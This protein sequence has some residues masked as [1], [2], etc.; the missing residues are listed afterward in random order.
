MQ[1]NQNK[2]VQAIA[3][4]EIPIFFE[5]EEAHTYVEIVNGQRFDVPT[6]ATILRNIQILDEA[7]QEKIKRLLGI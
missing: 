5:N 3:P 4:I 1:D 2:P 6:R 7:A